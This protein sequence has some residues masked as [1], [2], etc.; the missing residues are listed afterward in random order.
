MERGKTLILEKIYFI[1]NIIIILLLE[2][3][4]HQCQLWWWGIAF[5]GI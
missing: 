3:F 2:N 1:N 4:S 5:A